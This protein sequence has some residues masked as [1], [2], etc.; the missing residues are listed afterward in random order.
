LEDE[1][2][3]EKIC[4]KVWKEKKSEYFCTSQ[5]GSPEKG[6]KEGGKER[7]TKG[8]SPKV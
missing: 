1:K 2:K 5:N 8:V 3:F 6:W 7:K 4:E